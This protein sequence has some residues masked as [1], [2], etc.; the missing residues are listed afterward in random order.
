MLNLPYQSYV[1]W[2]VC[3]TMFHVAAILST[4]LRIRTRYKS[5]RMWLD[6]YLVIVPMTVDFIYCI[7]PWALPLL[8]PDPRGTGQFDLRKLWA[9]LLLCFTVIWFSR[10]C[11][12]LSLAR[13]FPPGSPTRSRIL[14]LV[15]LFALLFCVVVLLLAFHCDPYNSSATHCVKFLR[16]DPATKYA[17]S[18]DT[19]SDIIMIITPLVVLWKVKLPKLEKRII[20][21]AL[22]GSIMT[23]L[24]FAVLMFITFGPF[25]RYNLP[26]VILSIMLS[27]LTAASS[28]LTCNALVVVTNIFRVYRRRTG[29][30]EEARS[31]ETTS[32]DSSN[33]TRPAP[34]S[35]PVF[36]LDKTKEDANH[37][38]PQSSY[39]PNID[40]TSDG[41]TESEGS[42]APVSMF[43]LTQITM[44]D[45]DSRYGPPDSTNPRS[46]LPG[47]PISST[48]VA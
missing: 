10:I 38:S 22:S 20:L 30:I 33:P 43:T 21:A 34:T 29:R 11:F 39:D 9:V 48:R 4:L 44:E 27:H 19:I 32:A 13:I 8:S 28:L 47:V 5:Q 15:F 17:Y 46:R 16:F 36:E 14:S 23:L 35:A 26:Y 40:T 31:P 3:V 2:R 18:V 7:S 25:Q 41:A 42:A 45:Y 12:M 24:L 1:A 37:Q 6:D